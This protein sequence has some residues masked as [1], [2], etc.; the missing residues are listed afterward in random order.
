MEVIVVATF[1]KLALVTE[2][3]NERSKSA[4][5][6]DFISLQVFLGKLLFHITQATSQ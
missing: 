1:S 6:P 4:F 3:L 2:V 5:V